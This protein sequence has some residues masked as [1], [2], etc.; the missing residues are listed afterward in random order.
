M[1]SYWEQKY[2]STFDTIIVGAGLAG[3]FTAIQLKK[4]FPNQ[5]LLILDKEMFPAAST[6]NAGFACM[7][8]V[9]ELED[10]LLTNSPDDVASLFEKRYEG[11][12]RMRN[13]LGDEPIHYQENGSYELLYKKDE[14]ALAR[15][16]FWNTL[17]F[18]VAN[19]NAF[20]PAKVTTLPF[21]NFSGAIKNEL[22][23]EID[24][25]KMY[26]SL[27]RKA[28]RFG[29]EILMQTALRRYEKNKTSYHIWTDNGFLFKANRLILCTNAFTKKLLPEIEIK[30]A[31]GQVLLAKPKQKLNFKGIYHF[32][33]GYYYFREIDGYILFGG[34]RN[35]D[36]E[37]ETTDVLGANQLILKD[38]QT[39]L[40]E[41]ILVKQEFDIL[42]TW[43]GIMGKASKKEPQVK[44][45]EENLFLLAGFGGM[46]V[47][48]APY[49][50]RELV[51]RID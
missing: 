5:S 45:L 42:N 17:L 35:L 41:Q 39:K 47:A 21:K 36:E 37:T 16:S 12:Q 48:L 19:K 6:K 13:E 31:R 32:D 15:I 11:L 27:K 33:R 18:S 4:K 44:Q 24:T 10:D 38:L 29:V 49:M 14:A 34:G 7:G 8:S 50:A 26:Q 28:Q 9:S 51:K 46:G 20:T 22:E 1:F 40:R 3:L 30:P 25:G 23:G 2:F 43:S